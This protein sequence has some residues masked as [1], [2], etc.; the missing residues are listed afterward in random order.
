[1]LCYTNWMH[2][3]ILVTVLDIHNSIAVKYKLYV[4]WNNS[5]KVQALS[6]CLS[7]ISFIWN[8]VFGKREREKHTHTHFLFCSSIQLMTSNGFNAFKKFFFS[9]ILFFSV[10]F[11]MI[12][13][14]IAVNVYISYT[15]CW[16]IHFLWYL[17][18]SL[19][20]LVI[21]VTENNTFHYQLQL[22]CENI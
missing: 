20:L 15:Q 5:W 19:S 6:V 3:G 13:I 10:P 1:M 8:Y 17:S 11:H 16:L 14:V 9:F 18:L 2:I 12:Q 4:I 21:V 7:I 22:N